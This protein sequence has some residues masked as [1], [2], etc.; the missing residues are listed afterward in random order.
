MPPLIKLMTDA[1]KAIV[2]DI[3]W[4]LRGC[5]KELFEQTKQLDLL[6]VWE[7][8]LSFLHYKENEELERTKKDDSKNNVNEVNKEKEVKK[9]KEKERKL[10]IKDIYKELSVN[11][12]RNQNITDENH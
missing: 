10:T 8:Q 5:D 12:I 7:K 2:Q 9:R 3:L 4:R 11:Y 6:A 1:M